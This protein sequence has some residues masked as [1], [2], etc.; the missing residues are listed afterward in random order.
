MFTNL[1]VIQIKNFLDVDECKVNN[2]GCSHDCTNTI[3]S[4]ICACLDPELSLADDKHTCEGKIFFLL[5]LITWH[6]RRAYVR[7]CYLIELKTGNWK[8]GNVGF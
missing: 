7:D 1:T 4:Y 6:V 5:Y 8:V 2:D 3:G